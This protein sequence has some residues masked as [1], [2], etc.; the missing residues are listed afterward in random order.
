MMER[1]SAVPIFPWP[2]SGMLPSN[3][4]SDCDLASVTTMGFRGEALPE[5]RV[6]LPCAGDDRDEE[7]TTVGSQLILVAGAAG[8]IVNAPA[9]PGTR[10][11]VS[12]LFFNQP[13]RRKFLKSSRD[14][15]VSYQSC[16]STRGPRLA[17]G[18]FLPDP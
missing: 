12:N 6:R 3:L 5:H 11:E 18:T 14:G 16:R 1:G 9:V 17:I 13:A 10:I 7:Q 4:R 15:V 8:S 2:S